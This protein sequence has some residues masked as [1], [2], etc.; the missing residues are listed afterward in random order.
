MRLR[1][2]IRDLL[3]LMLAAGLAVGLVSEHRRHRHAKIL[4]IQNDRLDTVRSV[5]QRYHR[6]RGCCTL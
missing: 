3:W 1:G 4:Q 2:L 6:I 5:L